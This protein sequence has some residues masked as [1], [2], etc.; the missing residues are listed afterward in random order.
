[1]RMSRDVHKEK[2]HAAEDAAARQLH[3]TEMSAGLLR[4]KLQQCETL[5]RDM[6]AQTGEGQAVGGAAQAGPAARAEPGA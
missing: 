1:M 3:S 5:L 2:L 6:A 4:Q